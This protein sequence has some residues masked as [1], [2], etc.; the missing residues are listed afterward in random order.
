[1][2]F[3][4]NLPRANAP[5]VSAELRNQFNGL[6]TLIDAVP[7]GPQGSPGST[8]PPGEVSNQQ[9]TDTVNNAIADTPHN[10]SSIGPF[11]GTFSDPP[12]QAEMQAYAAWGESLRQALIR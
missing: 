6:K 10:P 12:T 3:D 11:T 9:L 2:A 7:A 5:V 1:M 4:P 8:G